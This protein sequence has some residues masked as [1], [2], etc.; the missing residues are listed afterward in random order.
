MTVEN[1]QSFLKKKSRRRMRPEKGNKSKRQLWQE[2]KLEVASVYQEFYQEMQKLK[3]K[4]PGALYARYSSRFQDSIASQIRA[5]LVFAVANQIYISIDQ[6]FFDVAVRGSKANREGLQKVEK[7]LESGKASVLLV[8]KTNRLYRKTY[9]SLHWIDRAVKRW[10]ARLIF[11]KDHLDSSERDFDGIRLQMAAV[12]D[13]HGARAHVDN[14][15]SQHLHLAQD[16]VITGTVTF[17]F[18]GDEVEGQETRRGFP[19]RTW[20]ID[21]F[22]AEYVRLIFHWFVYEGLSRAEIVRRLV[23][24]PDAPLPPRSAGSWSITA[25]NILLQNERYLGIFKYG[26]KM[27]VDMPDAD[28]V[29]RQERDEPLH[30]AHHSELQIVESRIWFEA[31]RLIAIAKSNG[32]RRRGKSSEPTGS[33]LIRRLFVCPQHQRPTW[34]SGDNI[35]CPECNKLQREQRCLVSKLPTKLASKLLIEKI[36]GFIT[37]DKDFVRDAHKAYVEALESGEVV[38][39][40]EIRRLEHESKELGRKIAALKQ[41]KGSTDIEIAE[42]D[43]ILG[44]LRAERQEVTSRLARLNR[45]SSLEVQIPTFEETVKKLKTLADSL[46]N[47]I[48]AKDPAVLGRFRRVLRLLVGGEIELHQAGSIEP[49][50]GWLRA[51]FDICLGAV[52]TDGSGLD[53]KQPSRRVSIDFNRPCPFQ[54]EADEAYRLDTAEELPRKEIGSRLGCSKSK[55]TKLLKY[56]YDQRG[57][58]FVDGRSR[59]AAIAPP[60]PPAYDR[61]GD[62]VME[63]YRQDRLLQVIA[64]DVGVCKDTITKVVRIWHE[65]N[66]VPLEDGR[67]RRKRLAVKNRPK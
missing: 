12:L 56:A 55:I 59:R 6:I 10:E 34:I 14:V 5:L 39:P 40:N 11:V 7:T 15:V 4:T 23:A 2:A 62:R 54:A 8:L 64:N 45:D 43:E 13:E 24:D 60:N 16:K 31:Q 32:G 3:G 20:A 25:L 29:I 61:I 53:D 44:E 51:E 42:S 49:R 35:F 58:V 37:E 28:Y 41:D 57:E 38:D 63:L 26:E 66:N 27:N 18:C 19:R 1:M 46:L 50:Q 67:T 48:R 9:R 30:V 21:E 47:S 22:E 52:L 17:G 33:E 36:V 65:E